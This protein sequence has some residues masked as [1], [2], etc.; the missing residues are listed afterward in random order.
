MH[1]KNTILIAIAVTAMSLHAMAAD[2]GSHKRYKW[3][4][5]QGLIHY[6]DTLSAEA[7]QTGYDVVDAQGLVI[8]HVD[9]ALTVE[10]KK[11]GD[12][13]AAAQLATKQ[14]ALDQANADQQL[15]VAYGSEE[16]LAASQKTKLTAIDQTVQNIR[17]SQS[18]QERSLVDQ[19]AHADSLERNNKPVPASVT[20]QIEAL[21]KNIEEQKIFIEHKQR[22]RIDI[23]QKSAVEMTHFRQL[24]AQH[25][26]QAAQQ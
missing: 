3:K 11:A 15:L 18:D 17:M 22:E 4:D 1:L 8:Q 24:R 10:E 26:A 25:A 20:Q 9:R 19:L 23:E 16:D 6:T 14:K 12:A 7:L 5:Q 21:R 2:S 13:A